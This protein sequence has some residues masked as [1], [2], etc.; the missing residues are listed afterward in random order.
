MKTL[1]ARR[2]AG[3]RPSYS[4]DAWAREMLAAAADAGFDAPP[5]VIGHSMGGHVTLRLA[6]LFGARIEGVVVLDSPIRDLP[7]RRPPPR[8]SACSGD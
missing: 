7:L 2:P 3:R 5:V 6:G 1:T 4:L 8:I